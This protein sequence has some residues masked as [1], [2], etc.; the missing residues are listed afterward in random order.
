MCNDCQAW[1]TVPARR[2]GPTDYDTVIEVISDGRFVRRKPGTLTAALE[3]L[4]EKCGRT[5]KAG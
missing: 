3:K 4:R 5:R 2:L 1:K